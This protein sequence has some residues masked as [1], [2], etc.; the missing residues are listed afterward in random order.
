MEIFK[1][2]K[3][4]NKR[5]QRVGRGGKRGT[6]SGKGTKGQKSRAGHKIRP[7]QR[8]LLIRFP[9]LRG[10]GNKPLSHDMDVLNLSD[11]QESKE[12]TFSKK[13]VG[14]V[15]ILGG[16]ELKKAVTVDGLKVSKSARAMIEKAG[17]QVKENQWHGK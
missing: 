12:T 9:K 4:K 10:F 16:G 7:A 6:T 3:Q 17:G 15:K 13:T 2:S 1:Y 11:L 14:D 5:V 8:D